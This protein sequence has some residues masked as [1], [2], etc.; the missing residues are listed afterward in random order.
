MSV[1]IAGSDQ[2]VRQ[3]VQTVWTT[4]TN[5]TS[6]AETN[7]YTATIT[8]RPGSRIF[9]MGTYSWYSAGG[10]GWYGACFMVIRENS[11][12][13]TI[14]CRPEHQGTITSEEQ[15]WNVPYSFLTDTKTSGGTF[16]YYI[17]ASVITGGTRQFNRGG[18]YINNKITL[19]EVTS[20]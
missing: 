9:G 6:T 14:V 5:L 19:F 12:S 15:A 10:G 13:G 16:T 2:I 18:D 4:P 17:D 8:V 11:T 20:G 3:V 7:L 1:T